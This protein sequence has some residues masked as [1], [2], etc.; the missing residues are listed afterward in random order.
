[1]TATTTTKAR[2]K[3]M[4]DFEEKSVEMPV[5]PPPVIKKKVSGH[6]SVPTRGTDLG[7]LSMKMTGKPV[8]MADYRERERIRRQMRMNGK[9]NLKPNSNGTGQARVSKNYQKPAQKYGRSNPPRVPIKK[10]GASRS[11][12][13]DHRLTREM[14][15]FQK[16]KAM[17]ILN[18]PVGGGEGKGTRPNDLA[19]K[20]AK[21]F[22]NL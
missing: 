3:K 2:V 8:G 14:N 17:Q 19:A 6:V 10:G 11:K 7:G 12:V 1:M 15:G 18:E 22:E 13:T 21:Y 9:G 5:P 16:K 20:R 4:V